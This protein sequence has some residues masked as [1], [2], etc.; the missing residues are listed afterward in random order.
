MTNG[1]TTYSWRSWFL[2]FAINLIGEDFNFRKGFYGGNI[3]VDEENG[4]SRHQFLDRKENT[5]DEEPM[6]T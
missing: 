3:D 1:T 4:P 5:A 6:V 2:G